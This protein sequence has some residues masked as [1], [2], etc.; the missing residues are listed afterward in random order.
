MGRVYLKRKQSR[1]IDQLKRV[2]P[3]PFLVTTIRLGCELNHAMQWNLDIWQI[4]LWQIMEVR[5][6]NAMKEKL[7]LAW[8]EQVSLDRSW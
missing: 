1:L 4:G 3:V 6:S 5:I 2:R 7:N 8:K